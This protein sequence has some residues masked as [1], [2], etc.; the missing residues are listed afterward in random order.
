MINKIDDMRKFFMICALFVGV[1]LS[2]EP[3]FAEEGKDEC[4]QVVM[5]LISKY[6]KI[7]GFDAFVIVKGQGLGLFKSALKKEF[8]REFLK[9]VDNIT[10]IDYSPVSQSV[11]DS[12]HKDY[13]GLVAV[14]DQLNPDSLKTND[15]DYFRIFFKEA[16]DESGN[17]TDFI[18]ISESKEGKMFFYMGGIIS[19]QSFEKMMSE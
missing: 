12:L 3:L 14:M 15:A 2:I 16:D 4:K 10:M 6:E 5:S 7:E 17:L 1:A 11:V 9:K 18:T 19:A 8:G 13:D